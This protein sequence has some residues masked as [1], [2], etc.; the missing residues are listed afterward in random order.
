MKLHTDELKKQP[1]LQCGYP[2][3]RQWT[4]YMAVY[5][6][7][8]PSRRLSICAWTYRGTDL[9][10][11][12]IQYNMTDSCIEAIEDFIKTTNLRYARIMTAFPRLT[13]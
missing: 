12:A 1:V 5:T 6:R 2:I 8:A 7:E 3:A 4:R 11:R 13:D 10:R 9:R